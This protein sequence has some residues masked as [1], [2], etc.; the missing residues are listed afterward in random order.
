MSLCYDRITRIAGD[1]KTPQIFRNLGHL[2]K[3]LVKFLK[4]VSMA[5]KTYV[6]MAVSLAG[7]LHKRLTR[8]QV[9]L[10]KGKTSEQ[11]TALAELIA[12]L[13]QFLQR[14]PKPPPNP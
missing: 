14:W 11:L 9:T 10:E 8:Y 12:C 2:V 6:P 4:G 5:E 7:G 3:R 1:A 13:A